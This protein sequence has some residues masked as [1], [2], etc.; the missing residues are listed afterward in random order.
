MKSMHVLK[1]LA[2]LVVLAGLYR[3]RLPLTGYRFRPVAAAAA[4]ISG[5]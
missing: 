2:A 4:A 1:A 3:A 5:R